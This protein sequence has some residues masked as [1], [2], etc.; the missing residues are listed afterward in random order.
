MRAVPIIAVLLLFLFGGCS[1]DAGRLPENVVLL[2]L[3]AADLEVINRLRERGDL[4]NFDRLFREGILA[5]I[6]VPPPVFSPVVWTTLL[7]GW[8][9]E[10]HGI[11]SFTLPV[12]EER[13]RVPV[14]SNL[15]R[16]KP[17]WNILGEAGIDVGVVGHWVTWPAEEVNGFLLSNYTWPPS[18]EFEKEWT[19]SAGWDTVGMRTFP[20]GLDLDVEAAVNVG[21]FF[22]SAHF[23]N[24]D[25]L[26]PPL[27]HYLDKD[28]DYLNAGLTLFDKHRPRFFTQYMEG[29]DFFQHKLWLY[30]KLHE[31][32]KFEGEMDG[33][34][35]P[36]K[37]LPP[38]VLD[39]IGPMV[40]QTYILADRLI[41][42]FLERLDLSRD[43]IVIVSDHGFR[44]WPPGTRLHVGDDKYETL[45]FWHSER[46]F[47]LAAG[48]PFG[49]GRLD[50]NLRPESLTPTILAAFALPVGRDM[51]GKVAEGVFSGKFLE[52]HPV[53][54]VESY[55]SGEE[56]PEND[57]P[58]ES[59]AD[60]QIREKL[61]SL[62]Y[63]D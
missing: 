39:R 23:P 6:D 12:G 60:E 35:G 16:K 17:L 44:T 53:T 48:A 43:A 29:I 47:L 15:V 49:K 30:H 13:R 3:D 11:E 41:G 56:R 34:A 38:G 10:N 62:G 27:R 2:G 36:E 14:T 51:D 18:A 63:L 26:D 1:R 45:P 25:R 55:E 22:A 59:P 54:E 4:P 42:L 24:V 32:E 19:P 28:F 50:G 57:K 21:R 20:E 31:S 52:D 9:P 37:P 8:R 46:A 5:E 33:L 7:T 58:I 40:G 61:K